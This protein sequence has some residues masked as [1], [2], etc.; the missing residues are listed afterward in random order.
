MFI[1]KKQLVS[2]MNIMLNNEFT[3]LIIYTAIT[4]FVFLSQKPLITVD[5]I[6]TIAYYIKICQYMQ[7]FTGLFLIY[8]F[9]ALAS[10]K[11]IQAYLLNVDIEI[12]AL[13]AYEASTKPSITVKKFSA[14][15]TKVG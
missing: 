1:S 11:R 15:W 13:R 10:I 3:S 5:V 4:M 6:F 14:S 12:P 8:Y 2:I 7:N 9:N